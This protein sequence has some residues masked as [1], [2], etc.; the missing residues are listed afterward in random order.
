MFKSFFMGGFE[1]STHRPHN[2]K[3][4]DLIAATRHDEFAAADYLRL[5]SQGLLTVRDGIR[6]H[7]IEKSPYHYDF[8]SALPMLRAAHQAGIQMIWDLCHYG[9]PDDLDIFS[10]EFIARFS[11]LAR[12]FAEL[13]VDETGDRHPFFS[14]INE[15]SFFSWAAG[16]VGYIYPFAEGRGDELKAQL[17]RAAIAAMD[18]IWESVPAARFVHADPAIHVA[19]DPSQPQD[20]QAADDYTESQFAAWDMIAGRMQPGLGGS[21][22]HLDIVGVNY[23]PHN[24]WV[25]NNLPFNPAYAMRRADPL[26]TPFRD[27]LAANYVRYGRPLF[28]AETGADNEDRAAWLHYIGGEVNAACGMG[29]PV[30][31]ICLYP[32]VNF[33]W[34]DDGFHLQNGLW[35]YA[36]DAGNRAIYAPLAAE[37]QRQQAQFALIEHAANVQPQLEAR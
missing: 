36:D 14:P 5:R 28:V 4:L 30:E 35:D 16:T 31:G 9:W 7:L 32:I 8:S 11:A 26:Y 34:W 23:Y 13:L 2:G 10:A 33:P 25:F 17:V 29:V 24:Q 37:M 19:A 21:R 20:Q 22:K 6:W 3:R 12:A 1:C 15:I 18:A 27:I